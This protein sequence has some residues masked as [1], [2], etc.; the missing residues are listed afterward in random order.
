MSALP[1]MLTYLGKYNNRNCTFI[2][3]LNIYYYGLVIKNALLFIQVTGYN[4]YEHKPYKI[5]TKFFHV[6]SIAA[7]DL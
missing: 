1:S 5:K 6:P 2:K 4:L 7:R 3:K